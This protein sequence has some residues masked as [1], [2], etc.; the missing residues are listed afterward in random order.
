MTSPGRAPPPAVTL[1]HAGGECPVYIAAGILAALPDLVERHLHGRRVVVVSDD[2]V[3]T[4]VPL[5]LD[6]DRLTFPAGEPSK[7]REE[8]ARLTD[9]MVSLGVGRDGAV[10]AVGGGVTA[11]L[12]GFV[13]ATY[14]RGIPVLQVPTSLLAMLDAA[15]GGKT[16]VDLPAG[17]N[18]VGAF[19]QPAAVAMDPETLRTLAEE[20]YRNG[21]P[22]AV[23]HAA[24]ADPEHFAWL[25]ARLDAVL[26]RDP[27]VVEALVRRSVEIKA[28]VVAADE[29]EAG[30][31]A[32]LNAGHTVGHALEAASGY[33]LRHGAAVAAGL[34]VEARLG[35]HMGVTLPGTADRLTA[36]LSRSGFASGVPSSV[37]LELVLAH[38]RS[39]KKA[40][41]GATRFVLLRDIGAVAAGSD[42]GWTHAVSERAV[43]DVLEQCR[44]RAAGAER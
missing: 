37:D 26:R 39:D 3:A 31:R 20:E 35:E 42:G 9:R 2:R 17:K 24:I 23:K 41:G 44:N 33:A 8:W 32:V 16:G 36:L 4:A 30:R 6:G 22:E 13:A 15:V 5:P 1:R 38:M 28:E 40:R 43:R 27:V 18:L 29:R 11:D 10:L 7:T 21:L 19:H 25:E 14:M 12:A 34:T